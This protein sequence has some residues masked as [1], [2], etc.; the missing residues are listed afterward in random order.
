MLKP[1]PRFKTE[2]E[3]RKFW[4]TRDSTDYADWSKAECARLPSMKPSTTEISPRL[5]VALPEQI[6]ISANKRD[7]DPT[8]A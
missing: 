5:P 4:E 2:A 3:E 6:K 8:D 1:I 7:I